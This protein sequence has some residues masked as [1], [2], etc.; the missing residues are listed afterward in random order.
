[1][2][3]RGCMLVEMCNTAHWNDVRHDEV[4]DR[5]LSVDHSEGPN[6]LIECVAML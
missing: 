5:T 3:T 4:E 1:M 6:A 2:Y